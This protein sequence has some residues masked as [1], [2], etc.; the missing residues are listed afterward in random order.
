M[1]SDT[2]GQDIVIE[3]EVERF[4]LPTESMGQSQ[5]KKIKKNK[6]E[7]F[8]ASRLLNIDLFSYIRGL[9]VP[10]APQ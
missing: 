1:P 2:R 3:Y 4:L 9:D 8:L 5:Q 10:L 6:V 7:D